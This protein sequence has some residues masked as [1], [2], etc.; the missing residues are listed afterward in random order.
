MNGPGPAVSSRPVSTHTRPESTHQVSAREA[1]G[2]AVA[3]HVAATRALEAASVARAQA[4]A[5]LVAEG[6]TTR[7][8]AAEL[9]VSQ[10]MVVKLLRVADGRPVAHRPVVPACG[11]VGCA[12]RQL[13]CVGACWDG[14]C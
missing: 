5:A 13:A 9:G 6:W 4:V 7:E 11:R 1:L 2:L 10:P 14:A 12:E 3:D 8:V